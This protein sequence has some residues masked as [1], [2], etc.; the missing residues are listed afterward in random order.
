M[1]NH[2]ITLQNLA[3]E[4]NKT[5]KDAI[6]IE[7]YTQQKGEL[8]IN[9]KKDEINNT[10][11]ASINPQ[12]NFIFLREQIPRARKNSVSLF[13]EVYNHV[14]KS[15]GSHLFERIIK[16]NLKSG[17]QL[18]YHLFGTA[19]SNIFL[20]DNE[21][22]I[23]NAFKNSR[24]FINKKYSE[25]FKDTSPSYENLVADYET[26]KTKLLQSEGKT[27]YTALK[28]TY[29]ILG[30]TITR[31]ILHRIGLEDKVHTTE[32]TSDDLKKI[33]QELINIFSEVSKPTPLIYYNDNVP[34]VLSMLKLQHLSASKF[35]KYESVNEA[36]KTFIIKSFKIHDID[37]E[38][39][40]LMIR[41]RNEL[42]KLY[43]AKKSI[44]TELNHSKLAYEYDHIAKVIMA[45]LQHLTKGT[46]EI[47]IEDVFNNNKL[48]HITLDPKLTPVQNAERYF[49]K[50]RKARQSEINAKERYK[51]TEKNIYLLEKILLH[52]DNCQTKDHLNEFKEEYAEDLKRMNIL[53]YKQKSESVPFRVFKIA[54]EYEIWVGKSAANNELL[55]FKYAKQNDLWFHARGAG[56]SHVVLKI[57]NN[58]QKPPKEIILQ[59]ASIAAYYSKMRN[60]SNVPVSYCE[61][62]YV[63]KPKSSLVG[64]VIIEREKVIFVDPELPK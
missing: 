39:K 44:E 4:L 25:V 37:K 49:E 46:K 19:A 17:L 34:R 22:V 64:T 2:F 58:K 28:N 61:R 56:G 18:V 47:D 3:D 14:I 36:I 41:I 33:F 5:L 11:T 43:R 30:S 9:V 29:P 59:T 50:A 23:I 45:N 51:N 24:D 27:T 48:I 20:I 10:L 53:L 38:K 26:F 40:E 31:E 60:S 1:I 21:K 35:E 54:P 8:N 12:M 62:K 7:I 32:L 57:G 55:T 15:I 42:D 13:P 6:I 16:I 52:L 63:R